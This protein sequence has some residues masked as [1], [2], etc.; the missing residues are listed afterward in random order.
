MSRVLLRAFIGNVVLQ[1][2]LEGKVKDGSVKARDAPYEP[3]WI[4]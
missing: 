4:T 2:L 1:K 3:L